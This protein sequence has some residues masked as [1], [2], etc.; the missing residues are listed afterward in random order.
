MDRGFGRGETLEKKKKDKGGVG[1][2][3]SSHTPNT[4][5]ILERESYDVD[6]VFKEKCSSRDK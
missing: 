1:N 2:T 6:N 5:T 4:L 3:S